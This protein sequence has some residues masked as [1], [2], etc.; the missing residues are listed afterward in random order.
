[1][2]VVNSLDKVNEIKLNIA[3][4]GSLSAAKSSYGKVEQAKGEVG[5]LY[6][7]SSTKDKED[8]T[9]SSEEIE[10]NVEKAEKSKDELSQKCN[11]TKAKIMDIINQIE[12]KIEEE[13]KNYESKVKAQVEQATQEYKNDAKNKEKNERESFSQYLSKYLKSSVAGPTFAGLE[14]LISQKDGLAKQLSE[15]TDS[16]SDMD[17]AINSVKED[18]GL[19]SDKMPAVVANPFAATKND[20]KAN[21]KDFYNMVASYNSDS[22]TQTAQSSIN[23]A[24]MTVIS[25]ATSAQEGNDKKEDKIEEEI[26][27]EKKNDLFATDEEKK[28]QKIE[29]GKTAKEAEKE[30]KEEKGEKVE[31]DE[32]AKKEKEE[33]TK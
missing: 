4:T 21:E 15:K 33:E 6:T 18:F 16:V 20:D 11:D 13:T 27:E 28:E 3:T 5:D 17:V 8:L 32:E 30:I 10:E 22:V 1:M 19:V 12:E 2:S 9:L 14:G 26:K 29:E 24:L 7:F 23:T 25:K 31:T